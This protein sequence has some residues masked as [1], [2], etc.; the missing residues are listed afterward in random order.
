MFKHKFATKYDILIGYTV[1]ILLYFG[2]SSMVGVSYMSG[3][4][5]STRKPYCTMGFVIIDG[6]FDCAW[7]YLQPLFILF[8]ISS[9]IGIISW[10]IT[11]PYLLFLTLIVIE[12]LKPAG[13]GG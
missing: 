10:V 4:I 8:D 7:Q 6:L 5:P 1:F 3:S 9:S 13:T 2:I 11:I 12:L